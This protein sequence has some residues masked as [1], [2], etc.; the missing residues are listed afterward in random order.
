MAKSG[1][2]PTFDR[3]IASIPPESLDSEVRQEESV[4]SLIAARAQCSPETLG[5]KLG[6][7]PMVIDDVV[8]E[9]SGDKTQQRGGVLHRWIEIDG[10]KATLKKLLDALYHCDEIEAIRQVNQ[11]FSSV[12]QGTLAN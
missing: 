7:K 10:K 3:L 4:I 2:K 11:T 6:L 9:F 5:N 1:Q 8:G 12:S